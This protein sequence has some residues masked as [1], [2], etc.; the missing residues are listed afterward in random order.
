MAADE[1]C[2]R[3]RGEGIMVV[4][5][6][7]EKAAEMLLLDPDLARVWLNFGPDAMLVAGD[8]GIIWL[9]NVQAELLTGY[10][11]Q[12]LHGASVDM[13]LPE[14]RRGLHQGH[15]AQYMQEPRLRPMGRHLD[16]QMQRR[17]GVQVPVDINLSPVPTSR[18]VFVVATIRR[19]Q[20]P[21]EV[22]G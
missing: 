19:R 10:T 3:A 17:N 12:E 1:V 14:D 9:A 15:R 13:L 8:D 21:G 16:L 18:G 2:G 7:Y 22:C 5:D 6:S 11:R 20:G 4:A